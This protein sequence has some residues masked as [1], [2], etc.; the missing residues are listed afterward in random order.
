MVSSVGQL[1][2]FLV[3]LITLTKNFS[4]IT[5]HIVQLEYAADECIL[6]RGSSDALFPNYIGEDLFKI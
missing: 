3:E 1:T 2:K 5:L 4:S 6:R